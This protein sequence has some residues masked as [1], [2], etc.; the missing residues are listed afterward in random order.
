MGTFATTYSP[1]DSSG[2]S[3]GLWGQNEIFWF[4]FCKLAGSTGQKL[5][6]CV[7]VNLLF[8]SA[9]YIASDGHLGWRQAP[10]GV[11]PTEQTENLYTKNQGDL[12]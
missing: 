8:N 7:A 1:L 4:F 12:Q 10:L 6:F 11:L 3:F 9:P 5:R 2:L